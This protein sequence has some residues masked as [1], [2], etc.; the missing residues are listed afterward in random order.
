MGEGYGEGAPRSSRDSAGGTP[1]LPGDAPPVIPAKAGIHNA[2]NAV[3]TPARYP[4]RLSN[5][6]ES[7]SCPLPSVQ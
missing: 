1:A 6:Y 3:G 7:S 2:A 5:L 4:N